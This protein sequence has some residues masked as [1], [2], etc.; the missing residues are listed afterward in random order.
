MNNL[1]PSPSFRKGCNP[2]CNAFSLIGSFKRTRPKK[3]ASWRKKWRKY[4]E[5]QSSPFSK[6]NRLSLDR[7][8]VMQTNNI[9]LKKPPHPFTIQPAV[10]ENGI[11]GTLMSLTKIRADV[12][13]LH[14]TVI[15]FPLTRPSWG[16]CESRC[17]VHIG[18]YFKIKPR[19]TSLLLLARYDRLFHGQWEMAPPTQQ[20]HPTFHERPK[21]DSAVP[22]NTGVNLPAKYRFKIEF[23]LAPRTNSNFIYIRIP[24]NQTQQFPLAHQI[25]KPSIRINRPIQ[26]WPRHATKTWIVSV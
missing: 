17:F 8:M 4:R 23:M 3:K 26:G 11:S 21:L 16:K 14:A 10:K 18:L 5:F 7:A 19:K 6:S 25:C 12:A 20:S 24:I 22:K 9:A 13:S 1:R 15:R 2:F